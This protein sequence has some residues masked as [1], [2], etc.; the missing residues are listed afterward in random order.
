[1]AQPN[2]LPPAVRL[3]HRDPLDALLRRLADSD[4]S[5]VAEW[6]RALLEYGSS[7]DD[8][9]DGNRGEK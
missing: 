9:R 8:A 4:D 1:V 5:L 3:D 2:T 6:S 7:A